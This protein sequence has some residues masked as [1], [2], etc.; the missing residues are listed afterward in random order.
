MYRTADISSYS[1]SLYPKLLITY[2]DYC[3]YVRDVILG[4]RLNQSI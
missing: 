4:H 2:I 3:R 1:H